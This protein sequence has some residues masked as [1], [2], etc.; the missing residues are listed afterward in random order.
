MK[1]SEGLDEDPVVNIIIKVGIGKVNLI[2][3]HLVMNRFY[4]CAEIV[5]LQSSIGEGKHSKLL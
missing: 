1:L 4:C 5:L 2:I 3:M